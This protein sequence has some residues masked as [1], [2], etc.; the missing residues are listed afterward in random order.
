V[1][2]ERTGSRGER[3]RH[4]VATGGAAAPAVQGY[5]RQPRIMSG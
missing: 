5:L 2:E 4:V 1:V 3:E